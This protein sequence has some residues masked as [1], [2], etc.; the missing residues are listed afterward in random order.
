MNPSPPQPRIAFWFRYGP[1]EHTE[2]FHAL[3]EVIARLARHCEVHYFAPRTAKPPPAAIRENA[4]IHLLPFSVDRTSTRDKFIKTALWVLS[5]PWV[6]LK[7]RRMGITGVFIDETVPLTG[8]IARLFFGPYVAMTIADFFPEVYW[9]KYRIL[10]PLLYIIRSLDLAA[11]R[12]LPLIF[13]RVQATK[14]YLE[15]HGCKAFRIIPIHDP[16]DLTLY[17]PT[18]RHSA[19]RLYGYTDQDCVLVH[20]GILH[21]NKG[22]DR[23]IRA[24]AALREKGQPV[25][26]LLIGDGPDMP[27]LRALTA[28]LKMEEHVRFTGW[29]PR[30]EDV[31]I[32][33][34][35]G[36]IGL[37]MRIGQPS[38]H[39]HVTG[40][41]VHSMACGLPVLAARL[42]GIAEVMED[43]THGLLFDP[44]DME[45]FQTRLLQLRGDAGLRARCG[46][47]ALARARELFDMERVTDATVKA[48]VQFIRG[49]PS[50]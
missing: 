22:N 27:Q 11:W 16:C 14:R 33:L 4:R 9:E 29:I 8:T 37:V 34:N 49:E 35:A 25:K 12:H 3:P 28:E 31:N 17:R 19:R 39:F 40:A 24:L 6:G 20:H 1:A 26:Y 10:R 50:A 36:D 23:I 13:T 21:P 18:D 7:C 15:E 46:E 5:L 38:D 47:A 30:L 44:N 43:G 45:E 2:L 48:L 42:K 32:A 41:L